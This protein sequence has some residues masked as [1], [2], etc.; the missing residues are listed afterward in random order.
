MTWPRSTTSLLVPR[1]RQSNVCL[2]FLRVPENRFLPLYPC[3]VGM[4]SWQLNMFIC[5][6]EFPLNL[7]TYW[8]L[9][10]CFPP[11]LSFCRHRFWQGCP[12]TDD[13][14]SSKKLLPA[15][16]HR[17]ARTPKGSPWQTRLKNSEI[18]CLLMFRM[19]DSQWK[20]GPSKPDHRHCKRKLTKQDI[21]DKS[22]V[23]A[24]AC[25]LPCSS[26]AWFETL[27]GV[28]TTLTI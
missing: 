8:S 16:N 10:I 28:G 5:L 27:L 20:D 14:L 3:G 21:E 15:Y 19:I 13:C 2:S 23:C 22:L 24:L 6:Q 9:V 17:A 25:T 4:A 11:Y 7:C 1:R 26:L 18:S 12:F